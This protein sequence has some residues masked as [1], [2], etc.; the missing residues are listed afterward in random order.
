MG[1]FLKNNEKVLEVRFQN[2]F[3]GFN[4]KL[5]YYIVNKDFKVPENKIIGIWPNG[6]PEDK[7]ALKFVFVSDEIIPNEE[8]SE[9]TFVLSSSDYD[10]RLKRAVY[11]KFAVNIDLSAIFEKLAEEQRF[12]EVKRVLKEASSSLGELAQYKM[13]AELNPSLKPLVEEYL[14]YMTKNSLSLPSN[15]TYEV[16]NKD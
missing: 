4:D 13:A 7:F 15:S 9:N 3:S 14:G 10:E 2:S 16:E 8:I 5:Y 12:R 6:T 11:P 1:R